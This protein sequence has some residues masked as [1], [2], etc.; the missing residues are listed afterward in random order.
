M[1]DALEQIDLLVRSR[2]ALLYLLSH[3]ERRVEARLRDISEAGG[4]ALYAWRSTRGLSGPDG[5]VLPDSLSPEAALGVVVESS[6]PAFFLFFDFH[7]ALQRSDIVR[8]VRDLEPVLAARGQAII[9][10]SPVLFL[11]PELEK[12]VTLVDVGLPEA[13]EVGELI[14]E[15]A[16]RDAL[17]LEAIDRDGLSQ[18]ALGLTASEIRRVLAR[19]RLS[20]GSLTSDDIS[21][22][23]DEKR[24]VIRKSRFLEFTEV[25]DGMDSV[26]GMDSLKRWLAARRAGFREEARK[27][28][29]PSPR[30]LFLLGV[31]GCGKSLMSKAVADYWKM[32]LLRLDLGS[33]F[34]SADRAEESLR[35]TIRLAERLA[36]VVLWID[37]LEKGFA[38]TDSGGSRALGT[39]LT[40][41][42]E[43]TAP[44]FVVATANDVRALPPELLRKGR[45]DE[46]FFVDLPNVHERLEILEIQLRRREREPEVF[47]LPSVAE[48]T[49]KFSGAEI[50][51]LIIAAMYTAFAED[52]EIDSADLLEAARDMVPLAITMDDHLKAL[53]EW[54]RPRARPASVDR[55]R[56]DF[57]E[58]WGT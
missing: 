17:P 40:W 11:P 46:I 10:V 12:D 7:V 54:A 6:E 9:I 47:D 44:V 14:D 43:K 50:E 13:A 19:I 25:V 36:P 56:I 8:Q 1:A 55:R 31:Q 2:Y 28:G 42:Q 20:G 51:Q 33:V 57:F 29:L 32:P 5:Q 18:A 16:A 34:Q 45:F 39:F 4:F 24:R 30:G 27:F 35:E 52:R 48:E 37:E 21:A 22:V 58:E 49:E 41:M 38:T 23:I 15:V 26:G 3:E 53:R